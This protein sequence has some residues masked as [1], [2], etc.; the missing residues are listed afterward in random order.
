MT[1][2]AWNGGHVAAN[3][4]NGNWNG[5]GFDRDHDRGFRRGPG[6]GVGFGVGPGYYLYDDYAYYDDPYYS[7]TYAYDYETAP[8]VGVAVGTGGGDPEYCMRRYRSYDPASG[9]F[10]GYD[11]IRHPCP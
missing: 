3:G 7:D 8:A 9:T 4:W 6:F 5:R 1:R 2:G 10:L 11:G